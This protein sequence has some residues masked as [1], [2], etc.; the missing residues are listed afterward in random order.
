M[1]MVPMGMQEAACAIIGNEVG[2]GNVPLAKKY[3]RVISAIAG[4][5]LILISLFCF[6]CRQAIVDLFTNVPSV[7]AL[8]VT[9]MPILAV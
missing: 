8:T 6:F 4:S 3:Y 9:I 2:A 7:N 5:A 1:F